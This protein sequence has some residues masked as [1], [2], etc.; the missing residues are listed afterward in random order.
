MFLLILGFVLFFFVAAKTLH[1]LSDMM[2]HCQEV[3][4]E[5]EKGPPAQLGSANYFRWTLGSCLCIHPHLV[6][7]ILLTGQWIVEDEKSGRAMV[8]FHQRS[9][10]IPTE[11][12]PGIMKFVIDLGAESPK[13]GQEDPMPEPPVGPS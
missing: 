11:D 7:S 2:N 4:P 5:L 3:H 9:E 8:A 10:S 13:F 6:R 1:L 12:E